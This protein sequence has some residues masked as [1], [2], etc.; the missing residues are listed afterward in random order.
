MVS[1]RSVTA[2]R[3]AP[4]DPRPRR[5]GRCGRGARARARARRR[6]RRSPRTAGRRGRRPRTKRGTP[7]ARR[8]SHPRAGPGGT[9]RAGREARPRTPPRRRAR[10]SGRAVVGQFAR[11]C[12][13][14]LKESVAG[15]GHGCGG[16]VGRWIGAQVGRGGAGGGASPGG[17]L[18][19]LRGGRRCEGFSHLSLLRRRRVPRC[20]ESSH[21]RGPET[22]PSVKLTHYRKRR[23]GLSGGGD[24]RAPGSAGPAFARRACGRRAGGRWGP[25]H[26]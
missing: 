8:R 21:L 5:A 10:R 16:S 13:C 12:T 20:E 9:A 4:L 24:R 19:G 15:D 17:A 14:R 23:R 6:T 22:P 25:Y 7:P 18:R 26:P 2:R 11:T 3:S 1:V